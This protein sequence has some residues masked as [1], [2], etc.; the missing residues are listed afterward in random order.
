[1]G[2]CSAYVVNKHIEE[3]GS[4][5]RSLRNAVNNFKR[6]G[7]NTRIMDLRFPVGYVTAKPVYIATRKP[8]AQSL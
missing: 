8:K 2:I 3:Q 6:R 1:V 4:Q 5:D 7:K